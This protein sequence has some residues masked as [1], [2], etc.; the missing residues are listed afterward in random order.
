MATLP[1]PFLNSAV[2]QPPAAGSAVV[3]PCVER[4]ATAEPFS[5]SALASAMTA[6]T[7]AGP[8]L[9]DPSVPAAVLIDEP[10]SNEG[11]PKSAPALDAP[12]THEYAGATDCI[13]EISHYA[14][15]L[16]RGHQGFVL[17]EAAFMADIDESPMFV[18]DGDHLRRWS[19]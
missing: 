1:N 5:N 14:R 12:N 6:D 8:G 16:M 11:R 10:S 18:R 4:S 17:D 2:I 9:T 3:N 15:K 19:A 13:S 7:A